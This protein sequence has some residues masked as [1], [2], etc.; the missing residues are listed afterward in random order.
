MPCNL[1]AARDGAVTTGYQT[2]MSVS[3]QR[4]CRLAEEAADT[5]DP[6]LALRTLTALRAEL[7]QFERQQVARALT[8]GSSFG[9]IAR[10]LGVSRQAVHRRFKGLAKRPRRSEVPPSPEVRLAVEYA[11][12][13]AKAL[14]A[15]R[16]VAAHL[17]L[18]VLRT[19][20]RRGAAALTAAGVEIEPARGAA[21]SSGHDDLGLR[22]LLA[23]AVQAARR[24]D[25]EC[26]EI[27][28][29]VR[30]ALAGHDSVTGMLAGAG[31]E[32]AAVLRQLD[33][34]PDGEADCLET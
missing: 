5:P 22:A 14:G 34:M 29:V 2:L 7:D 32:P 21:P 6:E 24:E 17:L 12:E 25:R 23:E 9:T 33:A 19:G 31:V 28:H 11:G 15:E 8:A 20:D 3:G 4:I 26:V 30:A 10:A 18:G 16:L 13:E 1:A 27:E